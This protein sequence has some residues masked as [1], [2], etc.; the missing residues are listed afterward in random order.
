MSNLDKFCSCLPR[1]SRARYHKLN[2]LQKR[3]MFCELEL[4]ALLYNRVYTV[5]ILNCLITEGRYL[6]VEDFMSATICIIRTKSQEYQHIDIQVISYVLYSYDKTHIVH[7]Y[8]TQ[9]YV[10]ICIPLFSVFYRKA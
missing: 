4:I 5:I 3:T 2:F 6:L 1:K 9:S 8:N 10:R 7:N